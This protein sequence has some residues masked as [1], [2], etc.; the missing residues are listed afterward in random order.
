MEIDVTKIRIILAQYGITQSELA[1]RSGI[2]RQNI[3]VILSKGR[4]RNESAGKIARGL[5]VHVCEIL[6]GEC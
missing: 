2:S 6:K 5:G 3:S 1:K 4:C